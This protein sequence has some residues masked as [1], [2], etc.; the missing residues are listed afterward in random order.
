MRASIASIPEHIPT[1]H[2][3]LLEEKHFA[4]NYFMDKNMKSNLIE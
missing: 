2:P 3:N 4:V 1:Y